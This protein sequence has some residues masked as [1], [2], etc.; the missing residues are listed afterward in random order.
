[1]PDETRPDRPPSLG[2]RANVRALAAALRAAGRTRGEEVAARA[3]PNPLRPFGEPRS[4]FSEMLDWMWA[5]LMLVWPLSVTI[6]FLVAQGI[7]NAPHDRALAAGLKALASYVRIDARGVTLELPL[8]AEELIRA[9][10]ADQTFYMVL[11]LRGEFIAGDLN[12]PL[13]PEGE[14]PETGRV[15][16]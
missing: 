16:F 6:T 10:T 12:V 14:P 1:M 11:G 13:P 9:D 2:W 8:P 5:P 15:R 4:L 7:A 3:P